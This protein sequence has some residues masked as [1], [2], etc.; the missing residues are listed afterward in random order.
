MALIDAIEAANDEDETD[1]LEWKSGLDLGA[2]QHILKLAIGILAMANRDP[3]AA[4]RHCEGWGYFVVGASPGSCSGFSSP[5]DLADLEGKLRRYLG[6]GDEAPRWDSHWVLRGGRW[7]LI[8]EV[9]PPRQ[10][11]P[12]FP[13]CASGDGG[14]EGTVYVRAGSRSAPAGAA[15]IR[16]LSRRAAGGLATATGPDVAV[17]IQHPVNRV[18]PAHLAVAAAEWLD[19]IAESL[20]SDAAELMREEQAE[21]DRLGGKTPRLVT[22]SGF[23]LP[24]SDPQARFDN[25]AQRLSTW[26][27]DLRSGVIEQLYASLMLSDVCPFTVHVENLGPDHLDDVELQLEFPAGSKVL[28]SDVDWEAEP[29]AKPPVYEPA[30]DSRRAIADLLG[31]GAAMGQWRGVDLDGL[32]PSVPANLLP[33]VFRVTQQDPLVI[34]YDIG[35]M[36]A[37]PSSATVDLV[38]LVLAGSEIA[39]LPIQWSVTSPSVSG[40][41]A[42]TFDVA[43]AELSDFGQLLDD[44]DPRN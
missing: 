2:R 32:Y 12:I 4:R 33:P 13:L 23:E 8:I 1:W 20:R 30:S 9:A 42:G 21:I 43:L 39:S 40:R 7:I 19:E 15:H 11:D 17:D 34:E 18:D 25:F 28:L 6:S 35:S 41:A 22:R 31:R 29:L 3:V 14:N 5:M 44:L 38:G 16:M 24:S 36:R 10:G 26:T 37:A 27:D